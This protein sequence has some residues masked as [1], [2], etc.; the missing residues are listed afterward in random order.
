MGNRVQGLSFPVRWAYPAM[1]T[2]ILD[3][4]K[5]PKDV[6][7]KVSAM[8]DNLPRQ[9]VTERKLRLLLKNTSQP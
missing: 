5:L 6:M 2:Q 3:L 9:V 1:V 4:L 8:G 7:E